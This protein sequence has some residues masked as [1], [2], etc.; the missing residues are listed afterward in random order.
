MEVETTL[1]ENSRED[2]LI[3]MWRKNEA[4]LAGYSRAAADRIAGDATV[5]LELARRL[6][7]LGC[8]ED[9]ALA[10]LL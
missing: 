5:E 4:L 1:D 6:A 3:Y 9:L 7:R 2:D 8:A 10:I